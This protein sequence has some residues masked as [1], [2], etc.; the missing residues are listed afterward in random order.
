[1][2]TMKNNLVS[3]FTIVNG[4]FREIG[5]D[6]RV[7]LQGSHDLISGPANIQGRMPPN[8]EGM[9]DATSIPGPGGCKLRHA[10]D[11]PG[12]K[13]YR[14]ECGRTFVKAKNGYLE[15]RDPNSIR[16]RPLSAVFAFNS[17]TSDQSISAEVQPLVSYFLPTSLIIS[18]Y[19]GKTGGGASPNLTLDH[20]AIRTLK[21]G[22]REQSISK[23][24][25]VTGAQAY[26]WILGGA[27]APG[28][29]N[30]LIDFD[31]ATPQLGVVLD[32]DVAAGDVAAVP[33]RLGFSFFGITFEA[34]P[35]SGAG[36]LAKQRLG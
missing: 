1:M 20:I 30:N 25:Q 5:D 19:Q 18:L 24:G 27:F 23:L 26:P 14:D 6:G 4:V 22:N 17:D 31:V 36:R 15:V 9:V 12:G 29:F 35:Q 13:C 3:R 28:A 7:I 11:L 33:V 2:N 32:L 34:L 21:I 10:K 8:E 16:E